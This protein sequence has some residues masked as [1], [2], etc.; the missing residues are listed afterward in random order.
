[1]SRWDFDKEN[2]YEYRTPVDFINVMRN[3][4]A[5]AMLRAESGLVAFIWLAIHD[6]G[7]IEGGGTPE[8]MMHQAGDTLPGITVEDFDGALA[9]FRRYGLLPEKESAPAPAQD[10]LADG[11]PEADIR[12]APQAR[13]AGFA[14]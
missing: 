4:R 9:I 6:Q 2:P 13:R 8:S 7:G 12:P 10:G 11:A 5:C 1:M 14:N 3:P